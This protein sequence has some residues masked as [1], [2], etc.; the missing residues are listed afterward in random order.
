MVTWNKKEINKAID[1]LNMPT[2][3]R[4]Q[5]VNLDNFLTHDITMQLSIRQDAGKTTSA[6]VLGL[7]LKKLYNTT[8]IYQRC[9][10]SQIVASIIQNL[11]DVCVKNNYISLMFDGE[12]NN[13][14]YYPLLHQFTLVKKERDENG[15]FKITKESEKPI[16]RCVSLEKWNNYKSGFNDTD[17]DF[18]LFDEF[19]DTNRSTHNQ[20]VELENNISTIT[21]LREN[22]HCLM[23]GNNQNKYSFWF[24]DFC[25][26]NLIESLTFGGYI[27]NI[28]ELGTTF[29]CELLKQSDEHK[30]NIVKRKI[31]FSGF[32]TPKMNA[33]NGLSEW[34][35]KSYPHISNT[36]MLSDGLQFNNFY[37][38]HRSRYIKVCFFYQEKYG[39]YAYLH[40][41]PK[42]LYDDNIILTEYPI[43]F[44]LHGFGEQAKQEHIKAWCKWFI[45][46]WKSNRIYFY[47]NSVGTLFDDYA[48]EI[49]LNNRR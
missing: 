8:T 44:E 23:L 6:L 37:I 27:E 4:N 48:K 14:Q 21:R 18:I 12:Y 47:S 42:P 34:Q 35:G 3:W 32:N 16:C 30:E 38:K 19:M 45:E 31:R 26:E 22:A 46:L 39:Y 9:D 40:Y 15:D 20:M 13:V 1:K 43:K 49:R 7:A 11:Y 41:S 5:I 28:T 24:E 25:I 10:N 2:R 36:D 17:A 33:F 29:C